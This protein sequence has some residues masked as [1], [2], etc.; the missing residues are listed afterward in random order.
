MCV[1]IPQVTSSEPE[2]W[3]PQAPYKDMDRVRGKEKDS[4]V[5]DWDPDDEDATPAHAASEDLA[6]SGSEKNRKNL[7]IKRAPI[8]EKIVE[9]EPL[10]DDLAE[11]YG[12][13]YKGPEPTR[14][15]DWNHKGR[16]SDF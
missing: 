13:F 4:D 16:V 12:F 14:F 15:G 1:Q 10:L 9:M 11:E 2:E 6:S 8:Q 3:S 5:D 7:L